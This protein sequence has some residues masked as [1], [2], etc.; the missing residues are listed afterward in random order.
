MNDQSGNGLDLG[1]DELNAR[2]H[3]LVL[4]VLQDP[5]A[6]EAR[7][8]E[9]LLIGNPA[10]Q[11]VYTNYMQDTSSLG[12]VVSSEESRTVSEELT[13]TGVPPGLLLASEGRHRVGGTRPGG[14]R[15]RRA[16]WVLGFAVAASLAALAG[17]NVS[18]S[19]QP[20]TRPITPTGLATLTRAIDVRW[21]D[22]EQGRFETLSRLQP[23]SSLRFDSGQVELV[24]DLGVE[25]L[26]T[27]PADLRVDSPLQVSCRRGALSARVGENGNGFTVCTP[28]TNVI[29]L[30]TEFSVRIDQDGS[31]GV[32]VFDGKVDITTPEGFA[33]ATP[34]ER[35]RLEE[36]DAVAI[37]PDG[38]R[39]RMVSLS[40]DD[41]PVAGG[42]K[43]EA[44]REPA[45]IVGV[46]DN[47]HDRKERRFYRIVRGGLYD[48]ARAFVDRRHEWNGVDA[49]GTP[50]LIRGADYIM[51]FN[52]DKRLKNLEVTVQLARPCEL[53]VFFDNR[54]DPPEWLESD[55][56][57][58]GIDIGLD[59]AQSGYTKN[60][61]TA[62][63]AG[64]SIDNTFS[65]WAKAVDGP[66]SV[67]LGSVQRPK[68]TGGN[69][70]G[71]AAKP[72]APIG[73]P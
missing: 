1:R 71:I 66:T 61:F 4:A 23:G 72:L 12:I 63:G 17:Y 50:E 48:D 67:T 6:E 25:L 49:A 53:F 32:A 29:D 7:E 65:V 73:G 3:R 2:V 26:V 14:G 39:R 52:N 54:L 21:E 5:G 24:F 57:D 15:G 16:R 51:P 68:N 41:V 30:G 35:L 19:M 56:R 55:F 38:E 46:S 22:P 11:A 28:V 59:Q 62:I 45:I 33:T 47:L 69:M 58:T 18:R 27:G 8:L 37:T 13:G 10:A 42:P 34:L 40:S 9:E 60:S 43:R 36:G 70:Y 44:G 31:T 64:N 20:E